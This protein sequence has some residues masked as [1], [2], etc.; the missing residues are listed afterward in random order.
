VEAQ[1]AG[2]PVVSTRSGGIPELI[3]DGITGVLADWADSHQLADALTRIL[4][5]NEARSRMGPSG[6]RHVAELFCWE[7]FS[8]S[9]VSQYERLID[10]IQSHNGSAHK[11]VLDRHSSFRSDGSR[12]LEVYFVNPRFHYAFG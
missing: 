12:I 1:S 10:K 9:Y 8:K 3:R 7:V 6:R 4:T 11:V 2:L 5:D